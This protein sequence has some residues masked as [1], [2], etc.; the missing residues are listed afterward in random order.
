VVA[1]TTESIRALRSE[2]DAP[3]MDCKRALEE[4]QGN[5]EQAKLLLREWGASALAKKS[6]RQASEGVIEVYIH[7]NARVGVLVELN[8]ETD[9]VARND[10][11]RQFAKLLAKQIA[12]MNPTRVG[13]ESDAPSN[14]PDDRPLLSM[15]S[16]V[17]EFQGRTIEDIFNELVLKLRENI[18][19][20]RFVRYE[21]G[22]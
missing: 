6:D 13:N 7:H 10:E 3:V 16:I 8:C 11:F 2:T 12:G 5:P 9:F 4:A 20:R 17:P 21:L 22:A 18:V 14:D 19:I 15:D 1:V